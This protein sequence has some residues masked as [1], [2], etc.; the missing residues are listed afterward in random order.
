[1]YQGTQY[2][3]E[4]EKAHLTRTDLW[5][6]TNNTTSL[7]V[8]VTHENVECWTWA[9]GKTGTTRNI[10][11]PKQRTPLLSTQLILQNMQGDRCEKQRFWFSVRCFVT[12][13]HFST[14]STYSKLRHWIHIMQPYNQ[15]CFHLNAPAS[16]TV[17][18]T[19]ICDMV[20]YM[21]NYV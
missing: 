17:A 13:I 18:H 10:S 2:R 9:R 1:M 5:S 21:R 3:N 11:T 19:K 6:R 12:P 8:H 7:C 4:G 20:H 14:K 15:K 16:K